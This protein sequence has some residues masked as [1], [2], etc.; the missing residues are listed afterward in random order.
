MSP[1]TP[2]QPAQDKGRPLK[3]G[4]KRAIKVKSEESKQRVLS[5]EDAVA[6]GVC[7]HLHM[8]TCFGG[9]GGQ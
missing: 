6:L 3:D 4:L 8:C 7:V 5:G 9:G 2:L 1:F